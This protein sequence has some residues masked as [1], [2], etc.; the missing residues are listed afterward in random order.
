M[1]SL[2]FRQPL[3]GTTHLLTLMPIPAICN[4]FVSRDLGLGHRRIERIEHIERIE[5]IERI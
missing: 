4:L 2:P 1:R 3:L 5:R